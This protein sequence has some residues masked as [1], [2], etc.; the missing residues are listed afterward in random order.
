MSYKQVISGL[1]VAVVLSGLFADTAEAQR[2][3][4]RQRTTD[5]QGRIVWVNICDFNAAR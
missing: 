4:R 5:G 2:R 1:F 3:C